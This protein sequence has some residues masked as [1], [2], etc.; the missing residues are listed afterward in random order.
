[1]SEDEKLLRHAS[2]LFDPLVREGRAVDR[3]VDAN[4]I[5]FTAVCVDVDDGDGFDMLRS[6]LGRSKARRDVRTEPRH[7]E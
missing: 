4:G 1:M 6:R 7:T 5:P 3:I 2:R